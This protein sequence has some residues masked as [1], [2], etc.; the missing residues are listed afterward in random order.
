MFLGKIIYAGKIGAYKNP[1]VLNILSLQAN[2][3]L[4]VLKK[5]LHSYESEGNLFLLSVQAIKWDALTLFGVD[6]GFL[7]PRLQK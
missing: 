2:L 7:D 3:V 1:S 5:V 4:T 6:N